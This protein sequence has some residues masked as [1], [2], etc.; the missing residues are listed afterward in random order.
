MARNTCAGPFGG[1]YDFYIERP[2]LMRLVGRSVW[3]IDA[4]PLYDAIRS[5]SEAPDG[6]VILDVPCGGGVA[7]RALRPTQPV[8]CIAA[9]LDPVM[10]QRARRRASARGLAQIELVQADMLALPFP[11]EQ[12]D[13][14]ASFSGLHMVG[15]P[16]RA[17]SELCRCLKPG[18]TLI[19][20]SFVAEG[21]LRQRVLFALGSRRG[22]ARPPSAD[23]LVRW[24]EGAGIEDVVVAPRRGFV[25]FRGSKRR[26]NRPTGTA[27]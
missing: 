21:A 3:G 26:S 19:G 9:D 10:L 16:Q 1:A 13:L 22:H 5:I 14:V 6:S 8:R 17:V 18:G 23:D 4:R 27:G 11:D 12:A 15:E 25:A 7:F 20:T 24:L 2:A